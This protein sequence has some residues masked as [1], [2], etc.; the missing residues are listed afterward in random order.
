[1]ARIGSLLASRFRRQTPG[2]Y[3][4]VARSPRAD[5]AHATAWGFFTAGGGL[6]G[7]FLRSRQLRGFDVALVPH[8][9][10][11]GFLAFGLGLRYSMWVTKPP[12]RV[13]L[14]GGGG[15]VFPPSRG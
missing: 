10:A 12:P 7:I 13:G 8:P 11:R 4:A 6:V 5:V 9:R 14:W 15:A 1:M 3:C 2:L